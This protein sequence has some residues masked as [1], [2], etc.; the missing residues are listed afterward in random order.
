MAFKLSKV[1][2]PNAFKMIQ[3][4]SL[5]PKILNSSRRAG[6]A[7][8]LRKFREISQKIFRAAR[9]WGRLEHAKIIF[10]VKNR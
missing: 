1:I 6:F 7:K 3:K 9:R 8:I 5:A 2:L 4:L 10:R